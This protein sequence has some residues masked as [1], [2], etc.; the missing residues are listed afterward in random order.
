MWE[1]DLFCR[2]LWGV[3][4]SLFGLFSVEVLPFLDIL[5]VEIATIGASV[6][7]NM[8]SRNFIL[9]RLWNCCLASLFD[10]YAADIINILFDPSWMELLTWDCSL[11]CFEAALEMCRSRKSL[12]QKELI[13]PTRKVSILWCRVWF[14]GG[15]SA[16][17]D[18]VLKYNS[19]WNKNN[20]QVFCL[21]EYENFITKI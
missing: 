6:S 7:L 15:D 9:N 12:L 13:W 5:S 14:I 4:T 20:F 2:L 11:V 17:G 19:K 10:R 1:K 21:S 18:S 3:T 16:G 8:Q